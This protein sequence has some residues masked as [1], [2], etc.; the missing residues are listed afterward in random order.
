[1]IKILEYM[2]SGKPVVAFD[3]PEHRVTGGDAVRYVRPND[4]RAL[5]DAVGALLDDPAESA[6]RGAAGRARIEHH[7]SWAHSER[8]LLQAYAALDGDDAT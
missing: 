2:A 6:V 8:S 1:M 5:A 3:M 4:H 7:L